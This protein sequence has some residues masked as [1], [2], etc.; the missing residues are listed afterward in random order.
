MISTQVFNNLVLCPVYM[1]KFENWPSLVYVISL[2]WMRMS[3]KER[4]YPTMEKSFLKLCYKSRKLFWQYHK[5]KW[6]SFPNCSVFYCS[7]VNQYLDIEN[8]I[9]FPKPRYKFKWFQSERV[10]E[11]TFTVKVAD[12][13]DV[14]VHKYFFPSLIFQKIYSKNKKFFTLAIISNIKWHS[15]TREWYIDC[16]EIPMQSKNITYKGDNIT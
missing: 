2:D 4:S 7:H 16:L 15:I 12:T 1:Q 14:E 5:Y 10:L 11:L 8:G 6:V 9:L 3:R 13:I